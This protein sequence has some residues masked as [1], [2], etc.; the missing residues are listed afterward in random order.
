MFGTNLGINALL[1]K[2]L[3]SA[4]GLTYSYKSKPDI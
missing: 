1:S 4:L 2:K 3:F